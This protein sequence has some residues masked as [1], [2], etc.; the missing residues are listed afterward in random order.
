MHYIFY[1]GGVTEPLCNIRPYA[2][3]FLTSTQILPYLQGYSAE[4][5]KFYD[6]HMPI[7]VKKAFRE[8]S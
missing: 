1:S 4:L 7:S 5:W 6:K 3:A 2:P 8:M